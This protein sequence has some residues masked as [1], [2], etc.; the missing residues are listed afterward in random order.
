MDS[1][2]LLIPIALLFCVITI[3]LLFWAIN[4]GQYDDL[5]R[6]AWRMFTDDDESPRPPT[7]GDTDAGKPRD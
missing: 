3:W 6:E 4:T 2:Y 5:D 1:L 7:T